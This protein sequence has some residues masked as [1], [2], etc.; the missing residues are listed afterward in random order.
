MCNGT[1]SS[2]CFPVPQSIQIFSTPMDFQWVWKWWRRDT[3]IPVSVNATTTP[4][5]LDDETTWWT[6][7]SLLSLTP[8]EKTPLP[9]NMEFYWATTISK[10]RLQAFFINWKYW[11]DEQL[12]RIHLIRRRTSNERKQMCCNWERCNVWATWFKVL[13]WRGRRQNPFTCSSYGFIS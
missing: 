6:S 13:Q 8:N 11:S 3:K 9:V 4:R 12:C 1:A 2:L 10:Q 7:K 5:T